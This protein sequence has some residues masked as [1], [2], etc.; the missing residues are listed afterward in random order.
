MSLSK[1]KIEAT[2]AGRDLDI[3]IAKKVLKSNHVYE[4]GRC[5]L[6]TPLPY[7]SDIKYAFQLLEYLKQQGWHGSV[8]THTNGIG[9]PE[10]HWLCSLEK[11][12]MEP[13]LEGIAETPELAIVRCALQTVL[14]L[15]KIR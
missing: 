8:N 12:D 13:Y 14:C 11:G 9:C 6:C 4:I 15:K 1:E 10:N 2:P 7:S 5:P 3:L